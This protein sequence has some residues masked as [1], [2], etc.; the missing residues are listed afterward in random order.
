VWRNVSSQ[1]T[2]CL[3]HLYKTQQNCH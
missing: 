1:Q 3:R 2:P